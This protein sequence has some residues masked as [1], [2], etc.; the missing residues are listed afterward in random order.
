MTVKVPA[1]AFPLAVTVA[2]QDEDR[3]QTQATLNVTARQLIRQKAL[4]GSE[5]I[6]DRRNK[7]SRFF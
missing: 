7:D 6:L 2:M 5:I 4:V 3:T 1:R